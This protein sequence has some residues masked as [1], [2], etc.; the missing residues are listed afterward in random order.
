MNTKDEK[1]MKYIWD[2]SKEDN[3]L[4]FGTVQD[5]AELNS[6]VD[7]CLSKVKTSQS[8]REIVLETWLALDYNVRQFLASGFGL[9]RYCDEDYD[10]KYLLLPNSFRYLLKLFQNTI[11]Y[12][13]ELDSRPAPPQKDA[14]KG[15]ELPIGFLVHLR[16]KKE[17][18]FEK[19]N[20]MQRELEKE[21]FVYKNPDKKYSDYHEDDKIIRYATGVLI[22]EPERPLERMSPWWCAIAGRFDDG[23]FRKAEDL[24]KARNKAAHTINTV[25]IGSCF[26]LT[27][28]NIL[29]KIREECLGILALLLAVD[30]NK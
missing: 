5:M 22:S 8:A 14:L 19:L 29:E 3:V 18:L 11:K 16:D 7:Q 17:E 1:E 24:N 15:L 30:T 10:L 28:P 23:W 2:E 9:Q 25:R 6:I 26:G 20:Q 4:F 27:E 13:Q 12:N 21:Y